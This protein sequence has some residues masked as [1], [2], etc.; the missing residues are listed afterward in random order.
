MVLW[1]RSLGATCY[2]KLLWGYLQDLS[3][4][5]CHLKVRLGPV[6]FWDCL[7]IPSKLALTADQGLQFLALC[8]PLCW[9][10]VFSRDGSCFLQKEWSKWERPEEKLPCVFITSPLK[11]YAIISTVSYWLYQ[12]G[13]FPNSSVVQNLPTGDTGSVPGLGRSPGEGN[14]NPLQY[15]CLGGPMDRGTWWAIVH[16]VPKEPYMTGTKQQ[17]YSRHWE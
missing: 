1:V 17:L 5:C 16:G 13:G 9:A 6:C 2:R 12:S 8:G 7:L 11:A 14:G 4:G 15:S 3:W 10:A